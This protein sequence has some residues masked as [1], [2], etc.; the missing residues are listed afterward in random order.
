MNKNRPVLVILSPGFPE[1]EADTACLPAQQDLVRLLRQIRPSLEL[2]I[3]AFQYPFTGK[4]YEWNGVPV[5]PLN[6]RNRGKLHRLLTL[7]RAWYTIKRIKKDSHIIGLFSFWLTEC[8]FIGKWFGHYHSIR[9]HCWM[10]GQDARPGNKYVRYIRPA[11]EEL[12]ALSDFLVDEFYRNYGIRPGHVVPS[13]IDPEAFASRSIERTIDLLAV[14]SLIPLKQHAV[15]LQTVYAL[16]EQLPNVVAVICG[17]GPEKARLETLIRQYG[18]EANVHLAGER[19]HGEVLHLMQ[20]SRILLH[21][22]SY[23]GFGTVCLEA[24]YAGAQVI[25]FCRPMKA[26]I[27][28]WHIV[29]GP[30]EMIEKTR[31]LLLRE[32]CD[33]TP[34]MTYSMLD[35]ARSVLRLFPYQGISDVIKESPI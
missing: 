5:I 12:V 9:H 28:H 18:L 32:P 29:A 30:D 31:D 16:K 1:N 3:V 24:L 10:L 6:G 35:N 7:V 34:V 22:S 15:F 26:A 4:P 21:P 23:E 11:S 27:A 33:N 19:P 14:G 2:V 17:K 25:S 20:Q 13:G 8:A